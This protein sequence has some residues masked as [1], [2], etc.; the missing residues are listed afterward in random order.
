MEIVWS[1][2]LWGTNGVKLLNSEWAL[3]LDIKGLWAKSYADLQIPFSAHSDDALSCTVSPGETIVSTTMMQVSMELN[4]F[5]KV[6]MSILWD[7]FSDMDAKRVQTE[8]KATQPVS[9]PLGQP[10]W[11][12]LKDEGDFFNFS[13]PKVHQPQPQVQ[14]C[15]WAVRRGGER[16]QSTFCTQHGLRHKAFSSIRIWRIW[17]SRKW[18]DWCV[19]TA[20]ILKDHGS[21]QRLG[22]WARGKVPFECVAPF[23]QSPQLTL[24]ACDRWN[25]SVGIRVEI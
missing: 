22:M 7:T 13:H 20:L 16:Q 2:L 12:L 21:H 5:F 4:R 24:K 1:F 23:M 9:W 6:D 18:W 11:S 10:S 14:Q 8:E 19:K 25:I 17:A 3:L 15:I